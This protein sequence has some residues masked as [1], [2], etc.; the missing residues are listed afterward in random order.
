MSFSPSKERKGVEWMTGEVKRR[1]S[2]ELEEEKTTISTYERTYLK[3][4]KNMQRHVENYK[5]FFNSFCFI[6]DIMH[7]RNNTRHTDDSSCFCNM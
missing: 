5:T 3:P 1:I 7:Y 6:V 2:E 4:K